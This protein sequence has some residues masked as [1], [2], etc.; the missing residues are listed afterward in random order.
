MTRTAVRARPRLSAAALIAVVFVTGPPAAAA[1]HPA[2]A[3]V[4][5]TA[6]ARPASPAPPRLP[7][8]LTGTDTSGIP[9]SRYDISGNDENG[10]DV[11]ATIMLFLTNAFFTMTRVLV[12]AQVW[13]LNW[14]YS[15]GPA[16]ALLGPASTIASAYQQQ[17]IG[18]IGLAG[19]VLTLAAF[20]CG[21][22]ILRGRTA[23]GAG[24]LAVS[25]LISAAA[26]TLLAT[27][28]TLLLGDNG[29]LG[30]TRDTA[31]SLAAITATGGT[32]D[33]QSPAQAAGPLTS[34]L[35]TTFVVQPYQLLNFGTL[36]DAPDVPASC[37]AAYTQIVQGGPWGDAGTPRNMMAAA[38][39]QNLANYDANL[40]W[41]RLMG[42][43]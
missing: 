33:S 6:A 35:V 38:G 20:C 34:T 28:A 5:L 31:M 14:A 3:P 21:L 30:Q 23:K 9:L 17:V 32:T 2:P 27:P 41:D 22:M 1:V 10:R 11:P 36:M 7:G 39:C 40:T 15:F 12:G 13:L 42:A 37:Q 19:T 26:A 24:E 16:H 25:V 8:P 18:R 29:L 43:L 4:V